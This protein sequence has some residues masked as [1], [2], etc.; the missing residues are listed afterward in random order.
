MNSR[1]E[2]TAVRPPGV[3]DMASVPFECQLFATLP[4]DSTS[5]LLPWAQSLSMAACRQSI[6][7][8]PVSDPE[9]F[10][11]MI[12]RLEQA[13]APS[14]AMYRDA[15]ARGPMQIKILAAYGLGMVNVN[16]IVWARSAVHIPGGDPS[17]GGA[18]Y[19]G[20][21]YVARS[22]RLHQLLEALL[23]KERDA[24]LSAFHDV[25]RLAHEDPRAAQ[26]N[27]VMAFVVMNAQM[28][29]ALLR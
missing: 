2:P 14:I 26:A 23:V 13:M 12:A 1:R 27:Q 24:A 10:R 8:A 7:L 4:R 17:F 28:Q 5:E 16:I 6:T 21:S 3:I 9:Q 20:T 18:S 22:Q 19:G 25:A 15:L 11:P 29:A